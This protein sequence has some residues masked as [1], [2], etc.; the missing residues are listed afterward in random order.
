MT[1]KTP[2]TGPD[3]RFDS[4]VEDAVLNGIRPTLPNNA[5]DD[6]KKI[7]SQCWQDQPNDRPTFK[8][9]VMQLHS[10]NK[11]LTPPSLNTA[12]NT[13]NRDTTKAVSSCLHELNSEGIKEP[14]ENSKQEDLVNTVS[15][16]QLNE[17]LN[18][19]DAGN[20]TSN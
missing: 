1:R 14:K 15:I 2:F 9:I 18:C 17:L 13:P 8:N 5:D 11:P 7:V 20:T 10:I 12:E 16:F 19:E 4:D 3:Y 6:L